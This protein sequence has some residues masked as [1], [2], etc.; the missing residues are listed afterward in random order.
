MTKDSLQESME[1][2]PPG[3]RREF[4]KGLFVGTIVPAIG[5]GPLA[6]AAAANPVAGNI[7]TTEGLF[8]VS[9]KEHRIF[10]I[11]SAYLPFFEVTD[12]YDAAALKNIV[13]K[14]RG[15]W[16]DKWAVLYSD[17]PDIPTEVVNNSQDLLPPAPGKTYIAMSL[18]P[19][20]T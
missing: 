13:P 5:L 4:L 14:A 2:P 11:R 1:F 9:E 6:G 10:F 12:L 17:D 15:K 19:T 16:K 3:F 20:I 8:L 7:P 18:S